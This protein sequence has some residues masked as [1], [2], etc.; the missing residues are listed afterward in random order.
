VVEAI[1]FGGVGELVAPETTGAELR[2]TQPTALFVSCDAASNGSYDGLFALRSALDAT[3]R[4]ARPR[5]V[6]VDFVIDPIQVHRAAAAG[7][8]AIVLVHRLVSDA[9]L[10]D[11]VT[12]ARNVTL[13]PVV[14]VCTPE[15]L[16]HAV[17]LGAAILAVSIRD[18]DH[19]RF[20]IERAEDLAAKA[21]GRARLVAL[22]APAGEPF[23]RLKAAFDFVVLDPHPHDSPTADVVD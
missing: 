20:M 1:A 5:L 18:R 7:A 2:P 6:A 15:E 11:L 17:G 13:E 14:E 21:L 19:G 22:S 3:S 23:E 12:C 4:D 9:V 8:D 16:E 10:A